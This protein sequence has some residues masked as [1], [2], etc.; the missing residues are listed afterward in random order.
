[1][2]D[3]IQIRPIN[4]I[5]NAGLL[6]TYPIW[7]V[8]MKA[9]C[10]EGFKRRSNP[11][12]LRQNL[13]ESSLSQCKYIY[14]REG[15][16]GLYRGIEYN[17]LHHITKD[18]I[19]WFCEEWC[20]RRWRLDVRLAER[21]SGEGETATPSAAKKTSLLWS[22]RFLQFLSR[23]IGDVIAYPLQVIVGRLIVYE[24]DSIADAPFKP[25]NVSDCLASL[26]KYD[27][28]SSL[29]NGFLASTAMHVFSEL[30]DCLVSG[31]TDHLPPVE[32]HLLASAFTSFTVIAVSPLGTIS[33]MQRCAS[34]QPGLVNHMPVK[35]MMRNFPLQIWTLQLSISVLVFVVNYQLLSGTEKDEE[36]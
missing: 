6:I 5:P 8:G 22:R 7:A 26:G 2:K 12:N 28:W 11:L 18:T 34:Y 36:S 20:I 25:M 33:F 3:D 9:Y 16:Y 4:Y 17:H 1:M 19:R 35:E 24:P 14:E 27:G 32:R 13:F 21:W 29:Y 31:L 10:N 30:V 23:F 15:I